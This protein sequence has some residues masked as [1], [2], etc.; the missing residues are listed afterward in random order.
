MCCHNHINISGESKQNL[1][2]SQ[3]W[4][5][6]ISTTYECS[7]HA[8]LFPDLYVFEHFHIVTCGDQDLD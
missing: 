7:Q 1:K 3:L 8:L 4:L 5:F 6:I 2:Y